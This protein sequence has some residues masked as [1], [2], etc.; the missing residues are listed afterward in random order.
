MPPERA[1]IEVHPRLHLGLISMHE[2]GSRKNGG[3]GFAIEEPTAT[4]HL[5]SDSTVS[6]ADAR[7]RPLSQDEIRAIEQAAAILAQARSFASGARV[8]ITG[9][10]RTHV[11]MGSGT[12]IKLAVLEGLSLL[13][14]ASISPSE[15]VVA[16]GR[17]GTSGIG[18]NTYFHG[19][20]VLDLGIPMD[21]TGFRPSSSV[22]ASKRPMALP[23]AE[24][25]AWPVVLCV[26]TGIVPKTHMQE[27]EFFGRTLPLPAAASFEAA[28]VA[29][30]DIFAALLEKD[31][32][33]FCRGIEAI[34]RTTW[35][36]L[37]WREYGAPLKTVRSKLMDLGVDCVGMSS[38]GPMLY[39]LAPLP[40]L[41]RVVASSEELQCEVVLTHV[42]NSGR[43][44]LGNK[45][46]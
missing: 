36:S 11:G 17:G 29:L 37:E 43:R 1:S 19:G 23:I 13:N 6:V 33:G 10:M 27:V 32:A 26:P 28:Y 46:A 22:S 39:S 24:M 38:L 14:G 2:G 45:H 31:Y 40:I 35:K 41:Q 18:I 8:R 25:P 15:L 34:Q 3:I 21:S 20:A 30:M 42:T 44:I 12:G 9:A 5:E 16:S 7:P 4:V